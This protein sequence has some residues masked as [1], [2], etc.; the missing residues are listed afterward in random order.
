MGA[1]HRIS[2]EVAGNGVIYPILSIGYP[3]LAIQTWLPSVCPDTGTAG[4][5]AALHARVW[6]LTPKSQIVHS[7]NASPILPC[8]CAD[9]SCGGQSLQTLSW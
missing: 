8:K 6:M 5:E 1:R 7:Q 9:C 4:T 3:T 2:L